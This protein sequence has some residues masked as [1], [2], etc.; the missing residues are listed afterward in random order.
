MCTKEQGF[1]KQEIRKRVSDQ[2]LP[3]VLAITADIFDFHRDYDYAE[4]YVGQRRLYV[5]MNVCRKNVT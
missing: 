5:I 4:K 2:Y 1:L 3:S